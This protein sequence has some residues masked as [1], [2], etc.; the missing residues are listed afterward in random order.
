MAAAALTQAVKGAAL[1]PPY[2]YRRNKPKRCATHPPYS[3]ISAVGGAADSE[4][5][6]SLN[7]TVRKG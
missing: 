5:Y 1:T 2:H 4:D 3:V 6:K 7:Y